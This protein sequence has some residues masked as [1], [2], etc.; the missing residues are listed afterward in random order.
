MYLVLKI[1]HKLSLASENPYLDM[2]AHL[3]SK[4]QLFIWNLS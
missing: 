2:L 1:I 4:V 3:S